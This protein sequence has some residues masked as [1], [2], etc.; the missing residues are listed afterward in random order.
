MNPY[1]LIFIYSKKKYMFR[2]SF[3][4]KKKNLL[5]NKGERK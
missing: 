5:T 2:N 1:S 4:K 3:L